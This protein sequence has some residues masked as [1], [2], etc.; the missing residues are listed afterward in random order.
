MK[1]KYLMIKSNEKNELII[2]E[3][4]ELD[5]EDFFEVL[6]EDTFDGEA[7]ESAIIKGTRALI[8][9][10]RTQNM[11]PPIFYAGKIAESVVKL[12]GSQNDQSMELLFD[13]RDFLAKNLKK[14][15]AS[16]VK[17]DE[18]VEFDELPEDEPDEL[19]ELSED[20]PDEPDEL[21]EDDNAI[22]KTASPIHIEEDEPFDIE[23]EG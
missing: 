10:L 19:N 18:P 23:E 2:R 11:Y 5:K 8:S 15:K 3:F 6:C 21:L 22:K 7:I 17:E 12:Y 9:A 20:K 1:Q 13:D 16:S 14:S 4:A